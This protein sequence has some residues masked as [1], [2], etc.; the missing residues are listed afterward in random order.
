MRQPDFKK[1]TIAFTSVAHMNLFMIGIFSF[2]F[3]GLE[4]SIVQILSHGSVARD[5]FV[6]IGVFY[7]PY[8]T[9]MIKY[10]FGLLH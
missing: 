3:I 6:L 7:D 1:I 9:F 4:G 8:H 5:L 10:V 2:N